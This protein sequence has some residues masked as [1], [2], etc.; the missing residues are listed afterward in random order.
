[1]F[2][3]L[4]EII[5][6]TV[7]VAK[8]EDL[9]HEQRPKSRKRKAQAKTA[10]ELYQAKLEKEKAAATEAGEPWVAVVNMDVDFSDLSNGAIELDWNDSFVTRLMRF[11]YTGKTDADVVD[12]W[13]T[14]VCRHVVLETYQQEQA[15]P[16][17]RVRDLGGGKR[18]YK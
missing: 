8:N 7:R 12:Q 9:P 15:D 11:G 1:M 5:G 3:R 16:T 14:D 10:Q 6:A 18:E 4:R 2:K 17:N 13:F